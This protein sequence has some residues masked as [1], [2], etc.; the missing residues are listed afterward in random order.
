MATTSNTFARKKK[1]RLSATR[2]LRTAKL[3]NLFLRGAL[4]AKLAV[5][6]LYACVDDGGVGPDQ[7]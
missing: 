4:G 5:D 2:P 1:N 3:T 6:I 7:A